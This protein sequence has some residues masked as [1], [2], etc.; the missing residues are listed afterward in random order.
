M[1]FAEDSLDNTPLSTMIE[2]WFLLGYCTLIVLLLATIYVQDYT[3][4]M[5]WSEAKKKKPIMID[6]DIELGL[7][8]N[9]SFTQVSELPQKSY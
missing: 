7:P 3:H 5:P 2:I 1:P 4:Y 9:V 8:D 6:R